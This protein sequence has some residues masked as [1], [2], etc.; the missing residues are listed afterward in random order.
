MA[1]MAPPSRRLIAAALGVESGGRLVPVDAKRALYRRARSSCAFC[2]AVYG[3]RLRP[4][5]HLIH[6]VTRRGGVAAAEAFRCIA[7]I[8]IDA[9]GAAANFFL[10]F[11]LPVAHDPRLRIGID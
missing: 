7:V 3:T 9:I 2:A 10:H 11:F 5:R 1:G 6:R 8:P 4:M